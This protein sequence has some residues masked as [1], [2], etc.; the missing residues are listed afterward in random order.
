MVYLKWLALMPASFFMAI[1]GR[2]LAP[3]LPFFVDKETHRLP[4][5][6][7]TTTRMGIRGTGNV[8][9]ALT[10]GRRTSAALRGFCATFATASTFRF[11]AS[12]FTRLT[13]GM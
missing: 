10:P 12:L 6:L 7:T 2:L 1:I 13:N 9:R 11:V 5:W 4:R 8:G 3:I